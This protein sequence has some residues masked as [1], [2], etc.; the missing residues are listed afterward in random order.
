[1]GSNEGIH[2]MVPL[3]SV[4]AMYREH[5]SLRIIVEQAIGEVKDWAAARETIRMPP[6]NPENLKQFHHRVW[7]VVSVFVNESHPT[8]QRSGCRLVFTDRACFL[9]RRASHLDQ[10]GKNGD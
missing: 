10:T 8:R 5:A 6:N 3:T 1:L 7:T 9:L 2:I 4:P